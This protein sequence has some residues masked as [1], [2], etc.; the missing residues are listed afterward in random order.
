MA[1]T[2]VRKAEG[3][4]RV[5]AYKTCFTYGNDF[6]EYRPIWWYSLNDRLDYEKS[7]D[8]I[9]SRCYTE[10]GL[11]RTG[12]AGC[13][14]GRDFE[15]ELSVI[16]KHEPKLFTAVNNIFADSYEYT[17]KYKQFVKERDRKK[18]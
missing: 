17:R 7:Y 2:G 14:Y 16:K 12:C 1:I 10:Y 18:S 15:F 4:V 11:K 3:G 5:A 6:D 8:I 13:P 9:H